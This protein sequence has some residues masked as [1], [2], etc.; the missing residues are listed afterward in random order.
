MNLEQIGR[1]LDVR[2]DQLRA[3][4]RQADQRSGAKPPGVFPGNGNLPSAEEEIRR[5]NGT[6]TWPDLHTRDEVR[7]ALFEYIEVWYNRV[8]LHST[9]D[10]KS[11][12]QYELEEMQKPQAA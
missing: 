3:W 10:Y 8:R 5:L 2:R 11:P 9:L 1:E 6:C 7:S 12:V 4:S